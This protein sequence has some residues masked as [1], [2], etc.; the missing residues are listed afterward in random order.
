M[1]MMVVCV[2]EMSMEK[3]YKHGGYGSFEHLLFLFIVDLSDYALNVL[4]LL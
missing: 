4:L 2:R 3:S 1:F